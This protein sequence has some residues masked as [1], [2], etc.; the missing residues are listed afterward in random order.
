MLKM[1]FSLKN[2]MDLKSTGKKY[3]SPDKVSLKLENSLFK[4]VNQQQLLQ[5]HSPTHDI[6]EDPVDI[7]VES[8]D[9]LHFNQFMIKSP[10][11]FNF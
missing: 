3:R 8:V 2:M 1:P 11:N 10:D 6:A 7:V 5:K 9:E 4:L